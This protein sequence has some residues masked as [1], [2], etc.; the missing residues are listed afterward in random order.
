MGKVKNIARKLVP[1]FMRLR[2]RSVRSG[3]LH[4]LRLIRSF[5]S[6][7]SRYRRYSYR[8][9]RA[10]DGQRQLSAMIFM[11]AHRVEKAFS[12]PSIIPGYGFARLR[13]LIGLISQLKQ[14]AKS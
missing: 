7:Y 3:A 4:E 11:E 12:L 5:A 8:K 13:S 2:F 14:K 6:D 1:D 10:N 9:E